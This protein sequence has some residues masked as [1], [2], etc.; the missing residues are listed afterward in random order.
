MKT[1]DPFINRPRLGSR[2]F[3]RGHV[4]KFWHALY[5]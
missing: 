5:K 2:F 1:I 4:R 3:I